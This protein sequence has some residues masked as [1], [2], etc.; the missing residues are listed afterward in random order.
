[1]VKNFSLIETLVQL[2]TKKAY[3]LSMEGLFD[4]AFNHSSLVTDFEQEW[5]L[6]QED[7]GFVIPGQGFSYTDY[8]DSCDMNAVNPLM[9]EFNFKML[10]EKAM[11]AFLDSEE[12]DKH[13]SN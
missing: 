3:E 9:S 10:Q 8:K 12:E 7:N 2:H 6:E 5:D 13:A 4:D 1:M 11:E